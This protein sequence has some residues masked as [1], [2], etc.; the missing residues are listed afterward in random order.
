MVPEKRGI[1]GD[2]EGPRKRRIKDLEERV[3]FIIGFITHRLPCRQEKPELSRIPAISVISFLRCASV[4]CSAIN[5]SRTRARGG[6][7]SLAES[8]RREEQRDPGNL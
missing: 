6:E 5:M 1:E 8:G 3:N 2:Q 4:F 7:Q